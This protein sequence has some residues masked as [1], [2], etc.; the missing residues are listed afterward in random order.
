MKRRILPFCATMFATI[1]LASVASSAPDSAPKSSPIAPIDPLDEP[2]WRIAFQTEGAFGVT[3]P[4]YN[5]LAGAR[6][7]RCFSPV[8]C[9]GGYVGYVNLKGKDGRVSN[10][11]TYA[12]I[13]ARPSLGKSFFLPFRFG[14]GFLPKNGPTLRA[15]MGLGYRIGNVDLTIEVAPS[16]W[17]TKDL[18]V[19]SIDPAIEIAFSP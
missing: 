6:L 14:A 2:H 1:S 11:L 12:Q 19:L 13:E 4:F 17:L 18:P 16:Y 7:D 8:V 5:H 9:F 15:A 10:V 3:G